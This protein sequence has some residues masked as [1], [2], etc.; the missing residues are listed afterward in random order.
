MVR[1]M[2]ARRALGAAGPARYCEA[3]EEDGAGEAGEERGLG[4]RS[5]FGIFWVSRESAFFAWSWVSVPCWTSWSSCGWSFCEKAERN[6]VWSMFRAPASCCT[7]WP[8]RSAWVSCFGVTPSAW[9]SPVCAALVTA[10]DA[11]LAPPSCPGLGELAGLGAGELAVAPGDIDGDEEQ[12]VARAPAT[13]S[14]AA[15]STARDVNF[16]PVMFGTGP[17]RIPLGTFSLL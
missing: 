11:V 5:Q 9:A 10:R 8:W 12:A 2:G 13:P 14:A 15:I 6:A 1:A 16:M 17:S 3:G 7:V 4:A